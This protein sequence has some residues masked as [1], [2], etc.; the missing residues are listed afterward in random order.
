MADVYGRGLG[1]TNSLYGS[2][3]RRVQLS[4][5]NGTKEVFWAG[6]TGIQLPQMNLK[7]SNA[8][9]GSNGVLQ[10]PA[11]GN[12]SDR[13]FNIPA[14]D[15]LLSLADADF[16]EGHNIKWRAVRVWRDTAGEAF[17]AG[18]H[19]RI[20]QNNASGV[21]TPLAAN[22][23]G[24]VWRING[25]TVVNQGNLGCIVPA[26]HFSFGVKSAASEDLI[27]GYTSGYDPSFPGPSTRR[28]DTV[29]GN[30]NAAN[31]HFVLFA[32]QRNYSGS[33][34]AIHLFTDDDNR[35]TYPDT[36][37]YLLPGRAT[38][39]PLSDGESGGFTLL[40]QSNNQGGSPLKK[41]S[42]WPPWYGEAEDLEHLNFI[43]GNLKNNWFLDPCL[44]R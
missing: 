26:L 20:D 30:Y 37:N 9:V 13:V 16:S 35:I 39:F 38:N 40:A 24:M 42:V 19:E 32:A 25:S 23:G 27:I 36:R 12:P 5:T 7:T 2:V 3:T 31:G 29:N 11:G 10:V 28:M 18:Q 4:W 15:G 17:T 8:V 6:R 1:R 43:I 14:I 34:G 41:A 44:G 33:N 22:T 21:A